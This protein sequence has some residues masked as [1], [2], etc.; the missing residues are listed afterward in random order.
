MSGDIARCRELGVARHL[1]K[2]ITPSDLLDSRAPGPRPDDRG[3]PVVAGRARRRLATRL[4]VLVAE[5][6]AVNQRVIVRLLEKLG[7]VAVHRQQRSG[8]RRRA[9]S[10]QPVRP[11]ADG[12]A[13][14]RDGR[15]D[16]HE[17]I[18]EREAR[19]PGRRRLPIM[20]LTAF[21]MQG[22]RERC[23]EA[24]MD[25]LSDEAD[26]ARRAVG[27]AEPAPG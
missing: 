24:G 19:H 1:V 18:R 26:Q 27:R 22:D 5:D 8:G 3:G 21:A 14:A 17:A 11:G 4:H 2:P 13:D 15:A 12:R 23:L 7:H 25:E 16:G 9:T 10:A 6:N 20:A